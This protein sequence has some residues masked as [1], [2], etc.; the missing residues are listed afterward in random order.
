MDQVV[1]RIAGVG[2]D[3]EL[4]QS[5]HALNDRA[6]QKGRQSTIVTLFAKSILDRENP[7]DGGAYIRKCTAEMKRSLPQLSA[8]GTL[9][10]SGHGC[11]MSQTMS[12]WF[13][14]E[15]AE[16]LVTWGGLRRVGKV[17]VTGCFMGGHG[18]DHAAKLAQAGQSTQTFAG[19]L[20][21]ELCEKGVITTVFART[22][23]V[24]V[25]GEAI[26]HTNSPLF[27]RKQI[28]TTTR[29]H[30]ETENVHFSKYAPL[31][32]KIKFEWINGRSVGS[33]AFPKG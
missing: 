2:G 18:A 5:A 4:L 20:H 8:E 30:V 32:S 9:Y 11:W 25:L 31:G 12:G 23:T 7:R 10:I 29:N 17:S 27:G 21:K 26:V 19:S 28:F 24:A 1:L 33:T 22:E 13:G 3:L 14:D 16:L 6:K 15:V